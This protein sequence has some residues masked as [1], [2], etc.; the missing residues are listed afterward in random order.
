MVYV[1]LVLIRPQEYPQW[2]L[3]GVPVLPLALVA[4]LGVWLLSRNKRFD[5]PQY[6]LILVFLVVTSL[7]VMLTGWSGGA[8]QQFSEFATIVVSFFLLANALDS[9]ERVVGAMAVFTVSA[10]VLALHG[11]HQAAN[12]VGWTGAE[13]VG[14]GRIQY[15]GI[16]SD[17]N[18]LGMLFVACMPMAAYLGSRGGLMGLRRLF[19]WGICVVLLYGV[20]LTHCAARLSMI[21]M[22]GIWCAGA[23]SRR[24]PRGDHWRDC[25]HAV[26]RKRNRRAGGVG[27]RAR[28]GLVRGLQMFLSIPCSGRHR[29]LRSTIPDRAQLAGAGAGRERHRRHDRLAGVRGLLLLD[30]GRILRLTDFVEG[31]EL[32]WEWQDRAVALTL[33]ASLVGS[34]P[35]HSSSPQLRD[36]ATCWPRWWWPAS[37]TSATGTRPPALN[38]AI[39]WRAGR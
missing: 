5:A 29:Q 1:L 2:P 15:V 4:A 6:V 25:W 13:L 11:A 35:R 8:L 19:W 32:A 3:S 24:A 22:S 9:R 20:Y 38:C 30:D 34:S 37:A 36:P 14:D 26:A 39:T 7:S 21:A 33:L 28:G 10:A 17:P 16:F 23:C 12:G 31:E 18:D 27:C